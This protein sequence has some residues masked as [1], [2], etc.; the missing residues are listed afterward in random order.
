LGAAADFLS[1]ALQ[2]LQQTQP[3]S[4]PLELA[5]VVPTFNEAANLRE[6]IQ[7]L[8][9]TLAG[10]RW[11]MIVVDDDSPDGTSALLRELA[12]SHPQVRCLRRI[13]RRGLSSACIEGML[14]THAPLLAV[15]DADLQ[16][17]ETLL[18]QMLQ[19]LTEEGYD[20][21]VGTRYMAG[22]G[23][24]DWDTGRQTTSQL[25]TRLGRWWLKVSLRDPMS[26]FFMVRRT[27][28]EAAVYNLSSLGFK[29]LLDLVVSSPKPLK[30]KEIP[31]QFRQRH[32]GESKLDQRVAF[33]Y[34]MLLADKTVGRFVPVSLLSF[35]LI[36]L[37]GV[38]VH[39]GVLRAAMLWWGW[40]FLPAQTLAVVLAMV[41]NFFLNNILTYRDQKLQGW[42]WVGGLLKFMV[43]C[44]VGAI[45][46]VGIANAVYGDL[47]WWVTSGLAG[48]L[49]G[50]GW[51]YGATALLVWPKRRKQTVSA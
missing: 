47:G 5:V 33:D 11:E 21:A 9:A 36:G 27:A 32:A 37:L 34:L 14:S 30:V 25:A 18:P 15:M 39:L 6:L 16:H 8:E 43:A 17:D 28:F 51:N 12:Q 46:N 20:L 26:G 49:V 3:L 31:L 24:G 40:P 38:P 45:A 2:P 10:R 22:G 7:R 29:L 35:G 1:T 48:I 13:G 4:A 23:V 50:F 42:A 44:G 41:F 19:A